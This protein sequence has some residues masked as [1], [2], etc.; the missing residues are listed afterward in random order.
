LGERKRQEEAARA[1]A[2]RIADLETLARR[3][4][5]A[6]QEVESLIEKSQAASYQQAVQLLTRLRDLAA[7]QGQNTAFRERLDRLQERYSRRQAFIK[8]LRDAGLLKR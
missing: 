7:H 6:W 4:A 1:E 2:R 3:E 5:Q 8:R